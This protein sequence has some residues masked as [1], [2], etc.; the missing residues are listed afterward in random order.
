MARIALCAGLAPRKIGSLEETIVSLSQTLV[1]RGHAITVYVQSPVHAWFE[2]QLARH[3]VERRNLWFDEAV[4]PG[5][6][7][8]ARLLRREFDLVWMTLLGPRGLLA[9]QI[10]TAWPTRGVIL[11]GYSLSS[12]TEVCTASLAGR[13]VDRVTMIRIAGV[14]GVSDYITC[15]NRTLYGLSP[16]RC[17]TIY[18]GVNLERFCPCRDSRVPG[19]IR[20]VTVCHL[21]RDKGVDTLLHAL[22]QPGLEQTQLAVVGDGPE[23]ASLRLLAETLGIRDRVCFMG[24]RDDVPE[25][26]R[27]SDVLVHP[28]RWQEAFGY[29]LAEAMAC[30]LPVVATAVGGVPEIVSDGI[31]GILVRPDDP[32][33]LAFVLQKLVADEGQMRRM[34]LAARERAETMF[35]LGRS[36]Q[37]ISDWCEA[38]LHS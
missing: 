1:A 18:N 35:G 34:G 17:V 24:L 33:D 5:V 29:V 10:A 15:R 11:D 8:G 19:P 27:A 4:A 32:I 13:F 38:A 9:R 28:A 31:S 2:A 16:S 26:L 12:R 20:L 22:A 14:A 21:I 3:G 36:V 6:F 30:G 23:E 37:Q 7:A 25:I